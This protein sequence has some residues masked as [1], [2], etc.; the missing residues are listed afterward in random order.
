MKKVLQKL[1]IYLCAFTLA[2]STPVATSAHS[3]RTDAQGGHHDYKNVSGLGS[4]H[5]H[6]GYGPHLHNNGKCPYETS[7]SSSSSNKVTKP[8]KKKT[9]ATVKKA[10]KKLN[11][12]GYNCGK[13]DGIMGTKTRSAIK[14]FQKAKGLKVTGTLNQ[15]TK[16]KLG[17]K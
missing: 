15:K 8:A 2:F 3:G 9:N 7:S 14:K 1:V 4:Y 6:H 13:A 11:K 16:K 12:L 17:I 5:Y 10:Q